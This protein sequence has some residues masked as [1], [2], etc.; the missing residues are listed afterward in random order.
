MMEGM[1]SKATV[2]PLTVYGIPNCD[3]VKKA[4]DWLTAQGI[5]YTFHDFK[6]QGVPEKLLPQW[7]KTIGKETLINRKGPTWRKLD[8]AVQASVVDDA[9]ATQ[10]MLANSSVIKRP[11]VVWADGVVTVGFKPEEF[12]AR[13]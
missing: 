4:R 11:V 8:A 13:L 10:V 2:S 7:L 12:A 6:K 9:S 5:D 1:T 3:T